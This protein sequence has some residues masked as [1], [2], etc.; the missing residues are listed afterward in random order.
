MQ[1]TDYRL[2]STGGVG[3]CA[4][5]EWARD[6]LT[7]TQDGV[8]WSAHTRSP[9][10]ASDKPVKVLYIFGNPYNQ[11][12]SFHRRGFLRSPYLHCQHVSGDVGGIS[13]ELEWSLDT[14]LANGRGYLNLKEHFLGWMT[15]SQRTYQIMFVKYENMP[16]HIQELS[17]WFGIDAPFNFTPRQSDILRQP[18]HI[19][20]SLRK[21]FEDYMYI[22]ASIP[23]ITI[24][25]PGE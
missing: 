8:R 7:R 14:Y 17:D 1:P 22:V 13:Q 11:L 19:V 24:K 4:V 15:H 18:A 16:D 25:G 12:L 5:E 20:N 10:I 3:S 9:V 21:M 23:D 2:V 6:K